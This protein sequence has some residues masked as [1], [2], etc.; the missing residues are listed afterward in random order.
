MKETD[1][2][3]AACGRRTQMEDSHKQEL[4]SL[5][6]MIAVDCAQEAEQASDADDSL[7]VY[8]IAAILLAAAELRAI[9][10]KLR[11]IADALPT[12]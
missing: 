12:A 2:E 11:W 1:H 9:N 7:Q 5:R 4:D 8:G 6:S 10:T 3:C